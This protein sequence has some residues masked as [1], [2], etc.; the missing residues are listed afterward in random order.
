[1]K[2]FFLS[3]PISVRYLS[4][5]ILILAAACLPIFTAIR[6]FAEF[7]I[8]TAVFP[9]WK[10]FLLCFLCAIGFSLLSISGL[11]WLIAYRSIK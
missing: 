10:G 4:F 6:F 5:S 7:A 3:L 11:F 9:S 2:G 8:A 1:M